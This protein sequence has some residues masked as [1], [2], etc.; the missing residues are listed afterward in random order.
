MSEVRVKIDT[1]LP[2]TKARW[3]EVC[4]SELEAWGELAPGIDARAQTPYV[5]VGP[6]TGGPIAD[7]DA[8]CKAPACKLKNT[9]VLLSPPWLAVAAIAR[10]ESYQIAVQ[11]NAG[12]WPIDRCVACTFEVHLDHGRF[13]VTVGTTTHS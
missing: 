3:R 1:T 4:I 7:L 2:G 9:R 6:R 5:V 13:V 12:W 8:E 10:D 11:T